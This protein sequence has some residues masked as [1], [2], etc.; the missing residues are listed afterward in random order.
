MEEG[1]DA[2]AKK[3]YYTCRSW[4]DYPR[5]QLVEADAVGFGAV[6]ID[7]KVFQKVKR[8]WF[9]AATGKGEDIQFCYEARKAGFKVYM[10]T[11]AKIGHLGPPI[12]VDEAFFDQW[13]HNLDDELMQK[14]EGLKV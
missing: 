6:L 4:V 5:D 12:N 14:P 8:P 7:T 1:F 2:V 11:A 3:N 10:D 9:I 13:K